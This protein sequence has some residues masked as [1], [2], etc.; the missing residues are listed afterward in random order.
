MIFNKTV[1]ENLR[2]GVYSVYSVCHWVYRCSRY[3]KTTVNIS[4]VPHV[5]HVSLVL[6][7]HHS[8]SEALCT[9]PSDRHQQCHQILT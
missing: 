9:S 5:S 7:K 6:T 1:L 2:F 3:A 8:S 4:F